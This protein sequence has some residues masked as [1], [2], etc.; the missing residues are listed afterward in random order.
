LTHFSKEIQQQPAV[1]AK[2][3]DKYIKENKISGFSSFSSFKK[4]ILIAS[5]TSKNAADFGA[6]YFEQIDKIPSK[7]EF[8]SEAIAKEFILDSDDLVI[9]ISQSGKSADVLAAAELVKK[10]SAKILSVVNKTDSPLAELSDYV[11]DMAA[12]EELAI[13]ATKSFSSTVIELYLL[14]VFFAQEKGFET[15]SLLKEAIDLPEAAEEILSSSLA[16]EIAKNFDAKV[17]LGRGLCY[18]AM[19][20][21]ALKLKEAALVN[22]SVYPLGEFVHGHMVALDSNQAI[23]AVSLT[24]NE[25]HKTNLSLISRIEANYGPKIDILTEEKFSLKSKYLTPLLIVLLFQSIASELAS[26]KGLNPDLPHG[27][28]KVTE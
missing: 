27:L 15:K 21:V 5:G 19:N 8:A 6:Y 9:F 18:F 20:E 14:A 7:V 11:I 22:T 24:F 2:I 16:F 13:P 25:I 10:T 28:K 4:I 17:F 26:K 23:W 12:G 1:M 3:L